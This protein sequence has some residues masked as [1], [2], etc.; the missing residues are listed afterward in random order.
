MEVS[1]VVYQTSRPRFRQVDAKFRTGKFC[2]GIMLQYH[3]YKS[4]PF[5]GKGPPPRAPPL[6]PPMYSKF[7]C[8]YDGVSCEI[9]NVT[10]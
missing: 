8:L 9:M 10:S 5:T 3:L 6:D 7:T 1:L 4:V 2:P